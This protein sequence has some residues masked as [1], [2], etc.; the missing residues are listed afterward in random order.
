[1]HGLTFETSIWLLAGSTRF[2][3]ERSIWTPTANRRRFRQRPFF[4]S[5]STVWLSNGRAVRF[6]LLQRA[7]FTLTH[8]LLATYMHKCMYVASNKWIGSFRQ[9]FPA[10]FSIRYFSTSRLLD[11]FTVVLGFMFCASESWNQPRS[12]KSWSPCTYATEKFFQTPLLHEIFHFGPNASQFCFYL[13]FFTHL[14]KSQA[15]SPLCGKFGKR[16]HFAFPRALSQ[17][18]CSDVS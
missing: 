13:P 15:L 11:W 8:L 18:M 1:M 16:A 7:Q 2:E 10:D 9:L 17:P 6:H 14:K 12:H 5:V 3:D 4:S